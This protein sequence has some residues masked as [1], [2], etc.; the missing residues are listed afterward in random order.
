MALESSVPRSRRAILTAALGGLAG[1][2]ASAIGQP[3]PAAAAAG[4]PLKLGRSSTV[5]TAGTANTSM[6]TKSTGVALAVTQNG[7]GSALK[8]TAVAAAGSGVVGQNT[9][10]AS[11]GAGVKGI[12]GNNNGVIA[13]T[14]NV[15]RYGVH[16]I[17]TAPLGDGVRGDAGTGGSG[18]I[19]LAPSGYG[20]FGGS[21]AGTGIRG[22]TQTGF[23]VSGF[24]SDTGTGVR[25]QSTNG[26]AGEFIG[27]VRT[28]SYVDLAVMTAPGNAESG[29]AR[30]FLRDNGGKAELC[31]IFPSGALQVIKAEP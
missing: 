30:L 8:G 23:G 20:V 28:T 15:N 29:H 3:G 18:V 4:D 2:V 16:G 22:E 6:K 7:S 10:P 27:V 13:S 25:G 21:D 1:M 11:S 5:N 14:S 9:G 31:V 17:N 12:G 19:G 26:F 24:A